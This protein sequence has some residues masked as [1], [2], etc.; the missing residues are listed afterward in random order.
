MTGVVLVNPR[1][2]FTDSA[3]VPLAGGSVI[4]YQAGTTIVATTYQD[5]ALETANESEIELDANGEC[6]LWVDSAY[7]YKILLKDADGATVSGYPVDNVP[8]AADIAAAATAAAAAALPY[9]T[10]AQGYAEDAAAVLVDAES[11]LAQTETA[12]DQAYATG[13]VYANTAAGVAGVASGE[14]F[15][16]VSADDNEVYELWRDNAGV[17]E[18]TGKRV[19]STTLVNQVVP[20]TVYA[21]AD[22]YT[23]IQYIAEDGAVVASA[24][25]SGGGG[26]GGGATGADPENYSWSEGS[27]YTTATQSVW[28][29]DP[30][31]V[32]DVWVSIGQSYTRGDS[33]TAGTAYNTSAIAAGTALMLSAGVTP[34]TTVSTTLT[35]M[36]TTT[37]AEPPLVEAMKYMVE[38]HT[39]EFASSVKMAGF[40]AAASG[41]RYWRWKK[42]SAIWDQVQQHLEEIKTAA[43]G[44][45]LRPVLRGIL[46]CAG[47]SDA[48]QILP[49][50]AIGHIRQLRQDMQDEAN[51]IFG[52]TDAVKLVA[53]S[54]NRASFTTLVE[55]AWP[56][57]LNKLCA[58]E[59]ELFANACPTYSVETDSTNHPTTTGY[60]ELGA[61]MGR[62]AYAIAYGTTRNALRVKN[63]YWTSTTTIRVNLEIPDGGSL[64]RD[65]TGTRVG[66]PASSADTAYIG[67]ATGSSARDGG[68]FVKDKDVESAVVTGSAGIN[69]TLSRAGHVGSTELF[70]AQFSQSGAFDGSNA[71]CARGVF[72]S[73]VSLTIDGSATPVYDWLLPQHLIL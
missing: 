21:D 5:K 51:R 27:G 34:D 44:L 36:L 16:V 8:G 23:G 20:L 9:V 22:L 72:R 46:V 67:P 14:Y 40:V 43:E 28:M 32:L 25:V 45:S 69:L 15:Y 54:N 41:Y 39:A 63:Y 64:V 60:R 53:Y 58:A 33:I 71:N 48:T 65:E 61:L 7:S 31:E 10:Q 18:D 50:I 19:P 4:V 17:A 59:P 35:D 29:P 73:G 42:G 30:A 57:A 1:T 47:E 13:K 12:R 56:I 37:D 55:T 68:W 38:A 66:Y 49:T 2:K 11:V 26:S 52:Q 6:L 24:G 3:G 70:Y 62:A